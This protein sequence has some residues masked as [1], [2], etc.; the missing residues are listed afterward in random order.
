M[1][2]PGIFA[3]KAADYAVLS[4]TGH[5]DGSDDLDRSVICNA[6]EG[7]RDAADLRVVLFAGHI[8][9]LRVEQEIPEALSLAES[10]AHN[11]AIPGPPHSEGGHAHGSVCINLTGLFH[12]ADTAQIACGLDNGDIGG[13][14]FF[15]Q[16]GGDD[17]K[18]IRLAINA[19]GVHKAPGRGHLEHGG[20]GVWQVFQQ[21]AVFRTC[22]KAAVGQDALLPRDILHTQNAAHACIAVRVTGIG[23]VDLSRKASAIQRADA[24]PGYGSHEAADVC[25]GRCVHRDLP[26]AQDI[27]SANLWVVRIRSQH[28]QASGLDRADNAAHVRSRGRY[29]QFTVVAAETVGQIAA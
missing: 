29:H 19:S 25:L 10:S 28:R 14:R 12:A 1:Q 16:H 26:E 8:Q 3:G 15:A 24:G 4:L 7:T 21:R 11:A 6:G 17:P 2:G 23:N 27:L 20:I 9:V 18:L 13:S 22:G 5:G